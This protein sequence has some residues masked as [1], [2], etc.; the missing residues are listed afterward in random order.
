MPKFRDIVACDMLTHHI[1]PMSIEVQHTMRDQKLKTNFHC[2]KGQ[3]LYQDK[4]YRH[5][6]DAMKKARLELKDY[7]NN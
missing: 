6:Y 1:D 3:D 4:E 2:N 7:V 5:V